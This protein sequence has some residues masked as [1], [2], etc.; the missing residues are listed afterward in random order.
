MGPSTWPVVGSTTPTNSLSGAGSSRWAPL[1]RPELTAAPTGH[2]SNLPGSWSA[3]VARTEVRVLLERVEPLL[4]D[5]AVEH[6]RLPVVDAVQTVLGRGGDDRERRH[7][8]RRIVLG[9]AAVAPELVHP[10]EGEQVL[11]GA[12]DEEGLLARACPPW[13]SRS[14]SPA[15]RTTRRRAPGT[16]AP[17]AALA[18]APLSSRV[19]ARALIIRIPTLVSLAQLGTSPQVSSRSWRTDCPPPEPCSERSGRVSTTGACLVGA[20]FQSGRPAG[21]SWGLTRIERVASAVR[22]SSISI[23]STRSS[24][25]NVAAYRPHMGA[26][27]GRAPIP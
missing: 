4:P 25:L 2:A 3:S 21:G 1:L 15:T 7:P 18:N 12:V 9:H 20:M 6:E 19:S 13:W 26:S 27:V 17:P 22:S 16:V 23:C 8:R 24:G 14:G 11:V 5:L 10:R